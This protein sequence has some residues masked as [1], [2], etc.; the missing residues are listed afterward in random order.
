MRKVDM[1]VGIVAVSTDENEAAAAIWHGVGLVM[2]TMAT[3]S[4]RDAH[5]L[6]ATHATTKTYVVPGVLTPTV[7]VDGFASLT[8]GV[9]HVDRLGYE[10]V[11]CQRDEVEGAPAPALPQAV[12]GPQGYVQGP[13]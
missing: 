4:N 8:G 3:T 11:P 1:R 5:V 13:L 2:A 9:G 12:D 10:P 6:P 7:P